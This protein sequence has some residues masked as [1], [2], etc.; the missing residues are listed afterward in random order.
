M[1]EVY[2]AGSAWRVHPEEVSG[3]FF[4]AEDGNGTNQSQT[5]TLTHGEGTC[6]Q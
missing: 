2:I 1:R 4:V 5:L 3:T 6:Y